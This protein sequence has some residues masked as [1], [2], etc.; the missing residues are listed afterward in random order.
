MLHPALDVV[1]LE[2]L[3]SLGHQL[4]LV[5]ACVVPDGMFFTLVEVVQRE[6]PLI[7]P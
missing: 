1:Y 3:A 2:L 6:G 7:W 5:Q 4:V